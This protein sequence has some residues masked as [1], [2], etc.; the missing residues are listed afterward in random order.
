MHTYVGHCHCN[1]AVSSVICL[2][3]RSTPAPE[4]V[5]PPVE[6]HLFQNQLLEAVG[7]ETTY[8]R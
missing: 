7:H 5:L 8:H 1:P 3:G 4:P 6:G 2:E